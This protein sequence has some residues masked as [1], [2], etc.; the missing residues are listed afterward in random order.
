[1]P[2][3]KSYLHAYGYR[4]IPLFY[5]LETAGLLNIKAENMLK[6]L[7]NWTSKW[8]TN[9][10]RLKLFPNPSKLIDLKGPTCPSYVYSGAYIPVIV[11]H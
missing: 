11:S 2:L 5:K 10:K 3:Q 1:M 9:A 7:P 8:T 4:N 6:R